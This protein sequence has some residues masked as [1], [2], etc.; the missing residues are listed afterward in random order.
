MLELSKAITHAGISA[1]YNFIF[2]KYDEKDN[3]TYGSIG[4]VHVG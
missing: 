4:V 3:L 1:L 2:K